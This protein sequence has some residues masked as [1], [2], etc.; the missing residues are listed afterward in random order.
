M[1]KFEPAGEESRWKII[2][3]L[4]EQADDDAVVT[5]DELG[6]ALELDPESDRQI[7]QASV[8]QA[9]K[10]LLPNTSKAIENVS[11][12]GYRIVRPVEHYDLAQKAQRKAKRRLKHSHEL[13]INTDFNGM[14]LTDRRRIELGAQL[15]AA[16]IDF[17]RRTDLRLKD[18]EKAVRNLGKR[19]DLSEG[20]T[21]KLREESARQEERIARLEK[22]L[23]ESREKTDA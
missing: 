19:Q 15:I 9:A 22:L 7:I 18:T 6:A 20:E 11:N 23:G 2:Y 13:V 4:L 16:Q 17:N 1:K 10:R 8:H 21:A 5:Y 3:P 14:A 12:K